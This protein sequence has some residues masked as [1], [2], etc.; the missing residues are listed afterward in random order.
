MNLCSEERSYERYNK[1][2]TIIDINTVETDKDSDSENE[3]VDVIVDTI[4][5]PEQT[6]IELISRDKKIF[7]DKGQLPENVNTIIIFDWDDTLSHLGLVY[8]YMNDIINSELDIEI[9]EIIKNKLKEIDDI[10]YKLLL[11]SL[12]KADVYIITN[13]KKIWI[14]KSCEKFYPKIRS[15]L[16]KI[17]VISAYEAYHR[18]FPNDPAKWKLF[19]FRK[20]LLQ[21][22]TTQQIL[23]GAVEF[24]NNIL[25]FGDADWDREAILDYRCNESILNDFS[26]GL[27]FIKS[28]KLKSQPDVMEF[29]QELDLIVN[30]IELF[31]NCPDNF[32][33]EIRFRDSYYEMEDLKIVL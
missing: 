15:L 24:K 6:N 7:D 11:L 8:P 18:M 25:S 23:N 28:I 3:Y 10:V 32:D 1:D 30:C 21:L 5:P 29:I 31:I 26:D 12:M 19:M 27:S 14:L 2:D 22:N 33:L 9:P 4:Y 20:I 17:K 13:A 16:S